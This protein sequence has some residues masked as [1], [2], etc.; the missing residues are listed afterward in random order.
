MKDRE[1]VD[2]YIFRFLVV[3][4]KM[5]VNGDDMIN[6][7]VVSKVLRSFG[8]KFKDEHPKNSDF[9]QNM[10]RDQN[11]EQ[12]KRKKFL[13]SRIDRVRKV[14]HGTIN[15]LAVALDNTSTQDAQTYEEVMKLHKDGKED[16][17]K[18]RL[19][20]KGHVQEYVIDCTEAFAH[21]ARWDIIST[22]LTLA[23]QKGTKV[24]QLDVNS[25]TLESDVRHDQFNQPLYGKIYRATH[26]SDNDLLSSLLMSLVDMMNANGDDMINGSAVSMVVR[27]FGPKFNFVVCSI[28]ESNDLDFMTN[29]Q[30]YESF[31]V[32]EKH[33][34]NQR[35]EEQ[36]LKAGCERSY[37]GRGRGT[38]KDYGRGRGRTAF[39]K[40]LTEYYKCHKLGHF[41]YECRIVRM[42][43]ILQKIRTQLNSTK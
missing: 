35:E 17:C 23:A 30:L 20:V 40:N 21:I 12:E 42:R 1:R 41:Q 18:A 26:G 5:K 16:K 6:G 24:H 19:V 33:L 32:H 31:I 43:Q 38:Y 22:I 9:D 2:T 11:K 15:E 36:V 37:K 27:S 14:L 34:L 3:V 8:P 28:M 13:K 25:N 7:F 39:N 4:N 10:D 29:N